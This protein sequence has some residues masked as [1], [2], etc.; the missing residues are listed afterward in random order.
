MSPPIVTPFYY[1]IRQRSTRMM[2]PNAQ[3]RRGRGFTHVEPTFDEPP[4]LFTTERGGITALGWWLKGVVSVSRTV[5]VSQYGFEE[6]YSE[7]WHTEKPDTPREREDFDVITVKV[8]EVR[9][10]V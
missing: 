9:D 3:G 7:T 8:Q 10:V 2:L 6:D 5:H 1:A 4:R